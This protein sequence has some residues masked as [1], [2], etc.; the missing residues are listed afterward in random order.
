MPALG[1]AGTTFLMKINEILFCRRH[2][3][4]NTQESWDNPVVLACFRQQAIDEL[5]HTLVLC[6]VS[7]EL[8]EV[9]E[10]KVASKVDHKLLGSLA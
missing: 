4:V 9:E 8:L 5:L 7:L 3:E 10:Q 2:T 1:L 6:V